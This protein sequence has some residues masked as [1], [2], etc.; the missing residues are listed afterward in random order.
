[1]HTLSI[2]DDKQT[3][4]RA[5]ALMLLGQGAYYCITESQLAL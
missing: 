4:T 2:K 3:L 1:M 5:L